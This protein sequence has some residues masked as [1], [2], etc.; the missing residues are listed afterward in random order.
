MTTEVV[1]P[2]R[3]LAKCFIEVSDNCYGQGWSFS[4]ENVEIYVSMWV[5][6]ATTLYSAV[7]LWFL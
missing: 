6:G 5:S 4:E 1:T 2:G 7:M 3:E